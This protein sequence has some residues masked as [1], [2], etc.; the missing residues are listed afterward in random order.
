M[1]HLYEELVFH[2]CLLSNS[3]QNTV[4]VNLK[5]RPNGE[6]PLRVEC[7]HIGN[8]GRNMRLFLIAGRDSENRNVY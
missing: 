5:I 4:Q 6:I 1:L 8:Y 7:M 2:T 3:L